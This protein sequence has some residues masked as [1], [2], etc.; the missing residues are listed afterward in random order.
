MVPPLTA[1][2]MVGASYT[3]V[4]VRLKNLSI[5]AD[6]RNGAGDTKGPQEDAKQVAPLQGGSSLQVFQGV[7]DFAQVKAVA[8]K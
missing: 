6:E 2:C 3:G 8:S 4:P 7:T 5:V 1:L